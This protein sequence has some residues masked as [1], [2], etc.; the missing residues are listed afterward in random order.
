MPP[1]PVTPFHDAEPID[2]LFPPPERQSR[3][4]VLF[5]PLLTLPHV[6]VLLPI[7]VGSLVLSVVGWFIALFAGRLPRSFASYQAHTLEYV[8]RVY[9]FGMLLAPQFPP[10]RW[11]AG[12]YPVQTRADQ[13]TL[14]RWGVFFRRLVS[15]PA[16]V[17]TAL[18]FGGATVTGPLIWLIVLIR[19]RMPAALH[20]ALAAVL[21]Y[22]LRFNGWFW[23]VTAVYPHELFGDRL[24]ES[25]PEP[26]QRGWNLPLTRGAR[27]WI[28]A[29]LALGVVYLAAIAFVDYRVATSSSGSSQRAPVV[30]AYQRLARSLSAFE[31]KTAACAARSTG[32]LRC[33]QEAEP[34]AAAALER[35]SADLSA[36]DFPPGAEA[37]ATSVETSAT[38]MAA[39]LRQAAQAKD[40]AAYLQVVGP[41][42]AVGQRL[43][44][45]VNA[46]LGDL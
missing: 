24:A 35:F 31:R 6:V 1:Q 17:V 25:W 41:L 12:G 29:F 3:L 42:A 16:L 39:L 15:I 37:D 32:R 14:R 11:Q 19:G 46:L 26:E 36:L 20:Y 28:G 22:Q 4:L 2:V 9:A 5:R 18:A 10:F 40:Q 7:L 27:R 38:R 23:M 21:R 43:D 8:A 30:A 33:V 34:P 45:S 44:A 13:S